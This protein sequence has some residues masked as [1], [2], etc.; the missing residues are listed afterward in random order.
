MNI[1]DSSTATEV[2]QGIHIYEVIVDVRGI[3]K[4]TFKG[5]A[6]DV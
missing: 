1:E 4:D 6:L 3:N 5:K 2:V